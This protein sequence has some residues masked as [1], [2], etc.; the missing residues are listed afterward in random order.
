MSGF[1]LGI[2]EHLFSK[3]PTGKDARERQR[4][5]VVGSAR[6]R[7]R[8]KISLETGRGDFRKFSTQELRASVVFD[9]AP[10]K[11]SGSPIL[12]RGALAA[13]LSNDMMH[14]NC[15]QFPFEILPGRFING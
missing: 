8:R 11:C 13:L 9:A 10:L 5:E 6:R 15:L 1:P 2:S 12:R 7:D 14:P 4:S 3:L